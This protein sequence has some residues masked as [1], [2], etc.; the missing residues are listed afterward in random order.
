M[1]IG[2]FGEKI[3]QWGSPKLFLN[4]Y[5]SQIVRS[6]AWHVF[7]QVRCK[8]APVKRTKELT[9]RTKELTKTSILDMIDYM[10]AGAG[11]TREQ[12]MIAMDTIIHY[13]QLHPGEK[14]NR[15]IGYLFGH[16]KQDR[17]GSLN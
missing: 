12:A 11:I 10:M 8:R 14:L 2:L 16:Q 3:Q 9:K 7:N 4:R 6:I 17:S 15:M 5:F 1:I 13:V